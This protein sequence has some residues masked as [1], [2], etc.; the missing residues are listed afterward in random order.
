[1]GW[2]FFQLLRLKA[3][4]AIVVCF[5]AVIARNMREIF[6]ILWHS[7]ALRARHD[8]VRTAN[9]CSPILGIG[10]LSTVLHHMMLLGLLNPMIMGLSLGFV[11]VK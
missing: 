6:G 8:S 5:L 7:L 2:A 9:G 4:V 11:F 1:M 10:H 3:F